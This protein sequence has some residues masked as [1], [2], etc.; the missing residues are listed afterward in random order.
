M[1]IVVG[2]AGGTTIVIKSKARSVMTPKPTPIRIKLIVH[3]INPIPAKKG[4]EKI[5]INMIQ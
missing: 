5:I 1:D 3:I 4:R 2:R